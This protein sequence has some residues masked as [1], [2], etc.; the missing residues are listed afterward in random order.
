MKS[1]IQL[2]GEY[3]ESIQAIEEIVKKTRAEFRKARF[4]CDS[5]EVRRLSAKL[6]VL[7][8]EIRDMKIISQKLREYYTDEEKIQ[9]AV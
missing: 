2:A 6:A 3:D 9:E 8:E 1:L 7:Y 4:E 5:D